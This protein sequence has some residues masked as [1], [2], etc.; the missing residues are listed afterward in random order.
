M[1]VGAGALALL[2]LALAAWLA[3][4]RARAPRLPPP[5]PA[6]ELPQTVVLVPMRDEEGN[7]TDCLTG[8]AAMAGV[9]RVVAI[10]DAS[11]DRTPELLAGLAGRLPLSVVA[12]RP[13]PAGWGGKVNALVSGLESLSEKERDGWLLLTDADA[14]H[15]PD[16]LARAHAAVDAHG[17]AALS[18]A[19]HQQGSSLGDRILTPAV[20][21]LLDLRL[22]DWRPYARGEGRPPLANGQFFL[23]DGRALAAIGGLAAIAPQALDDVALAERL[24]AGGHRVG[25]LRAGRALTVRMYD[26]FGAAFAGWRRNLALF[27]GRN[28]PLQLALLAS[29]AATLGLLAAALAGGDGR[30]AA[31]LWGAGAGA[32]AWARASAGASAAVGLFFPCDLVLLAV[33]TLLAGRDRRRGRLAAWRGRELPPAPPS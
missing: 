7:A 31:L 18:L 21:A 17:L 3:R 25:F 1:T 33:V 16:L 26:G 5:L 10:D 29:A 32:S 15:A 19:G 8:L 28:L 14:R 20:F 2:W 27:L 11:N 6:A 13:L 22:R 4:S 23:L 30:A 9:S 24:T 12:A